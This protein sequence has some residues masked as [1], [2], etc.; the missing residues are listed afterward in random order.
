METV[1]Q[2]LTVSDNTHVTDICGLVHK[3]PDLV[4]ESSIQ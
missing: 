4:Y 1:T 2:V 3:G